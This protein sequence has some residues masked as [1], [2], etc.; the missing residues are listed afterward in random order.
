MEVEKIRKPLSELGRADISKAV[1]IIKRVSPLVS[2]GTFV[3]ELGMDELTSV[4]LVN[5]LVGM[6]II[7]PTDHFTLQNGSKFRVFELTDE[8]EK[9]RLKALKEKKFPIQPPFSV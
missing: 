4:Q 6:G 7:K 8:A 3:S 9:L 5:I 1:R 2:R